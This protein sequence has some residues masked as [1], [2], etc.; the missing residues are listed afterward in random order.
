MLTS[1]DSVKSLIKVGHLPGQPKCDLD[2][3]L[4][5]FRRDE[6][7]LAQHLASR[8]IYIS[9]AHGESMFL[10]AFHSLS[11]HIAKAATNADT[12]ATKWWDFLGRVVVSRVTGENPNDTDSG[13]TFARWARQLAGIPET[14]ILRPEE[15]IAARYNND[16]PLLLVDDFLG[17]GEQII[18]H[19][20][21]KHQ[22]SGQS[23][24]DL[25]ANSG[26]Y[27]AYYC[28]LVAT[29]YGLQR[30]RSCVG[31]NV[32]PVYTMGPEYSALQAD[33]RIWKNAFS[34]SQL[35]EFL[36][37]TYA[38]AAFS[39][40]RFK[41]GFHNLGLTIGLWNNVPDA[42]IQILWDE[43]LTWKPLMKRA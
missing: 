5:N 43:S 12:I 7:P 18:K 21:R 42:S 13:Y 37:N 28:P 8:Y 4:S 24:E 6:L 19:W 3:W 23:L 25:F 41:G 40:P 17:S 14:R 1:V 36:N 20:K 26:G 32:I 27:G 9:Q 16:F 29:S 30:A 15:V 39:D 2:G 10:D 34:Q 11:S 33:S 38:R 31:L 35:D 22:L